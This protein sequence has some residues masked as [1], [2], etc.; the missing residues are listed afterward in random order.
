MRTYRFI[1]RFGRILRYTNALLLVGVVGGIGFLAG[2]VDRIQ[3]SLPPAEQLASYR[4]SVT[5]EI[6][7]TERH[8]D[9]T[10]THTLLARYYREDREPVALRDIPPALKRATIA[11]EDRRFPWHRGVDPKGLARAA[12]ANAKAILFGG[13]YVQGGSTITQQLARTIWLTREKTIMRKLKEILLAV[14]LERRYSKDEILEMYL[15]EVNYGHGA[16]GVKTAARV[17][18]DKDLDELTLGQCALLAG[19]PKRPAYYSPFVN[20][21][22]TRERRKSVLDWMVAEGY[23][24][25]AQARE[26]HRE[27][28]QANLAPLRPSGVKVLRAPYFAEH[29]RRLLCQQLSSDVFYKGGLRVYTT[30]DWRLQKI[31]DEELSKQ[32]KSLRERG[33]I[34][35]IKVKG[36]PVGQGALGCIEVRTGRVLAMSG[37]V[38][39]FDEVQYYNRAHP[40]IHPWGR[41]PGSSFKPYI[42]AAALE[43]GFGPNSRVSGVENIHIGNWHPKNYNSGQQHMWSIEG[44]LAWS[45]NLAAIRVLREISV[46]KGARYACRIIDLPESRFDNFRYL[47]LALG[48]A[49]LSPLEQASGY[50]VFA[51]GGRRVDRTFI[52]RIEDYR[53]NTL[54]AYRPKAKRVIKPETAISMVQMLNKVITSGT[55]RRAA[56]VGCPAGGKTGTTQDGWDAWW[57][58]ITPDLSAAVWVG[59]EDNTSMRGASGGGFCAPVWA[60]FM[61]R[62]IDTLGCRGQFPKGSGVVGWRHG[63]YEEKKEDEKTYTICEESGGLATPYCPHTR[64]IKLPKDKS[65]PPRCTIHTGHGG[66]PPSATVDT[67]GGVPVSICVRSGLRAT[68]YC[69]DTETRFFARGQVPRACT[70]HEAPP[71]ST[72]R[73]EEPTETPTEP[74][75][76][77]G[78]PEQPPAP[79]PEPPSLPVEPP[80]VPSV[81]DDAG[82]EGPGESGGEG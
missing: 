2:A 28:I 62:A 9:G 43:S 42:Y 40:G 76:P 61:R 22:K 12:R 4:P 26:A 54:F 39:P 41:Q 78:T 81:P 36:T 11:R 66:E 3:Q 71:G 46:D 25:P 8:K 48:T 44:A 15:N 13:P 33:S 75:P 29:V 34:R 51:N 21:D 69:P 5:T 35:S 14:E 38:G 47:S 59:N 10:E 49:N 68:P 64:Q 79:E 18:F 77:A 57:I 63:K 20:P 1:S 56:A 17:Y 7:S 82:P 50:A 65:A 55:G 16:Y 45:V 70:V 53:G 23:I 24:D 58:G 6:Y 30:L 74:E 52:D 32:V 73:P 60:K 80:A 19:L 37:G 27:Q 67:G 31:A 72:S